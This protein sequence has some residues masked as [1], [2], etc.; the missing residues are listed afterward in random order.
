MNFGGG[1]FSCLGQFVATIEV[2]EATAQLAR[3]YPDLV[4]RAER[5]YT[6]MFQIIPSLTMDR[7]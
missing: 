5:E 7:R 3:R 6:A 1:A 4:V 2:A